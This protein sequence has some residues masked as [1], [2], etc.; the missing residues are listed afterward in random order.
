MQGNG[1]FGCK[2]IFL[3]DQL[4]W[5]FIKE[6]KEKYGQ[7]HANNQELEQEK[8]RFQERKVRNHTLD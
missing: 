2:R 7:N 4:K 6:K 8:N 5:E 3:P 1:N